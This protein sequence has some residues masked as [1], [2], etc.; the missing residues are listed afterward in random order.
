MSHPLTPAIQT[1]ELGVALW[2]ICLPGEVFSSPLDGKAWAADGL[3]EAESALANLTQRRAA[4]SVR[5]DR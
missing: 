4:T 2:K 1:A 5:S 3:R